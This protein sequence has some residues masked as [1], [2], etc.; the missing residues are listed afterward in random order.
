M[1]VMTDFGDDLL[2]LVVPDY[3]SYCNQKQFELLYKDNNINLSLYFYLKASLMVTII[4]VVMW[5]VQSSK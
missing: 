3:S 1:L 4:Y 5:C 2:V